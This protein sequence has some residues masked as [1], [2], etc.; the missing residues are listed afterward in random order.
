MYECVYEKT[1]IRM[2]ECVYE[3][4]YVRIYE[5]VYERPMYA[6]MNVCMKDLCT[7]V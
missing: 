2:Y 5:C 3:K 1:Y 6:C 4:T 7:H